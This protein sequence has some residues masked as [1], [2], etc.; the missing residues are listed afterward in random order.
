MVALACELV[1]HHSI[2]LLSS[3]ASWMFFNIILITEERIK[4]IC[5]PNSTE[6]EV[7][8]VQVKKKKKNLNKYLALYHLSHYS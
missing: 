7:V 3:K 1:Y 8:I 4:A 2:Q 5:L 6:S